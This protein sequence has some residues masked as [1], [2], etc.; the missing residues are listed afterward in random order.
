MRLENPPT[1]ASALTALPV[2]NWKGFAR[3]LFDGR[4]EQ[5]CI[6]LEIERVDS[7]AEELEQ[8]VVD[9][10]TEGDGTLSAKAKKQRF[11]EQSWDSLRSSPKPE[12]VYLRGER[13]TRAGVSR[14]EGR[15]A[16]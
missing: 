16:P 15:R 14:R 11:E 10:I 4:I 12:E 13:D 2:M 8:L 7:E 3:E 5:I 6:L 9:G 1:S